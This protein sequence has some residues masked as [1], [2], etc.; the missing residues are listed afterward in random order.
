MSNLAVSPRPISL[1]LNILAALGLA[2]AG[3]ASAAP[4][5]VT[6]LSPNGGEVMTSGD[7]V[8]VTWNATDDLGIQEIEIFY[9][10]TETSEWTQIVRGLS[11]SGIYTWS[12]Q[13]TPTTAARV[14]VVA[15]DLEWN[16][17]GDQS[18]AIF[19]IL[20]APGG[21]V[22]TTLRDFELPGSQPFDISEPL[23]PVTLCVSCHGGYDFDVEPG[24]NY[25]GSMMAHSARDPLFYAC[26][27]IVEQDATSGG[28]YCIRCHTPGGW[29]D[30]RSNPTDGSALTAA[31]R[32]GVSCDFCHS[33]ADPVYV[34]GVSPPQDEYLL[35]QL[36]HVPTTYGEGQYVVDGDYLRRGP[37]GDPVAPHPWVESPFHRSSRICGTCHNVSNPVFQRTSGAD[38]VPGPIDEAATTQDPGVLFPLERTYS[39]WLA[40]EYN[41]PSGVY[42]PEFA[43]NKPDGRVATCEDCHMRDVEG[44]GCGS[45]FAPVRPDLPLHD[46]TGGNTFVPLM[47]ADLYPA[48]VDWVHLADGIERARYMLQNAAEIDVVVGAE[49]DSFRAEVTVTNNTGHKLP[50]GYPEGRRMWIHLQAFNGTG[51]LI[52]ESGR[53]N[54]ATAV[55][56]REGTR[57]Y[58]A[59]LGMSPAF[60]G[61]IGLDSGP[62]FHFALNDSIYKDTRIPARG[63]TNAAYDAFGGK[64]VDPDHIGAG[65]RYADGQ[66]WDTATYALP[67]ETRRVIANLYYQT[68]SLEY[69]TFLRDENTTN[70]AGDIL[71]DA[72]A[73][74]GKST[75]ELMGSD[76]LN[77]VPTNVDLDPTGEGSSPVLAFAAGP[78][79]AHN[80]VRMEFT[81]DRPLGLLIDVFDVQGRQVVQLDRGIVAAGDHQITWDGRDSEGR[82]AGSGIFWMRLQAG[83]V[84][85]TRRVVR[86][87]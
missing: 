86:L 72:W 35:Q 51:T 34:E 19:T 1:C 54:A 66:Y 16:E 31:D 46:L 69:V 5:N 20:Q 24:H 70:D 33:A 53:Y 32:D 85:E 26:L 82:D 9:R 55:L 37:F 49:A 43:G 21:I 67:A 73:A 62:S 83:G 13:N 50:T 74:N 45:E 44:Q 28:D 52:Y 78:N 47:V 42:A 76:V 4:P 8:S 84:M 30:G 68:A 2:F 15:T 80:E 23:E 56:E 36:D 71:Y 79:P 63:F 81:L 48:E 58:E 87:R 38:Y 25:L 59:E 6:V 27:A 60:A 17:A 12:P 41:T 11:D 3:V 22:A 18:D 40:S 77:F 10:E 65:P 29:L 7:P 61:T 39:E 14:R 75:P 64:P 57:I